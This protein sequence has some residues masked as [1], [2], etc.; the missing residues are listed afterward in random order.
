M[1][2]EKNQ[3]L[4]FREIVSYGLADL[5][6]ISLMQLS[7]IYLL[8]FYTDI[9]LLSA[10]LAG[11][12]FLISRIWDAI[13]DP[14]MGVIVD[15]TF[16]RWGRCRPY[17]IPGAIILSLSTLLIFINP[18][19]SGV[20]LIIYVVVTYNLFN[21]AFTAVNLPI[22]AQ[23]PLMTSSDVD[24]V[25]LSSSRAFFQATAYAGVPIV[26]ELLFGFLGER[27]QAAPYAWL[28]VIMSLFCVA[29]LS[30][31][32]SN[33]RERVFV[34]PERIT[35]GLIKTVFLG[36]WQW[37]LIL[38][39]NILISTA[40]LARTTSAIYH[41]KI[42]LGDM[43][44]F[45]LFMTLSSIAMIPFS[46]VS[47]RIV[48]RIGKRNLA[49]LGCLIGTVGNLLILAQPESIPW[50][51]VGSFLSGCAI[52]AFICVLFAIEGDIADE[53]QM[54]TGVRAQGLVCSAIALG[55]KIALGLGAGI[56]GWLLG[57][58]GYDA[59]LPQ[60]PESVRQAVSIAFIWI[61]LIGNIAGAVF[62]AF[63]KLDGELPRIRQKLVNA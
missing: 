5:G 8:Y 4:S 16:T 13:N 33:T 37:F 10:G 21:M 31:T 1:N 23:L 22:T 44:W 34:K 6:I 20:P 46:F 53:A 62:L 61:P 18:G 32:F 42:V 41:F 48:E 60:Q 51:L 47:A 14:I 50:L 55:Y 49:L 24:R 17:L 28:A 30:I 12:I 2:Q 63:Y 45:G 39:A 36:R 29:L 25:R 43:S 38:M 27:D 3:H 54:R 57:S 58:G 9:L 52:A 59:T 26:A 7:S 15:H 19:W 11:T 56:V 40:L 35:P